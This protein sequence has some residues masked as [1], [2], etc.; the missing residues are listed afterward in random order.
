MA[1]RPVTADGP[2]ET[3]VAWPTETSPSTNLLPER[4]PLRPFAAKGSV[5]TWHRHPS[6][7][8]VR[9]RY[10]DTTVPMSTDP[11]PRDILKLS[12]A[13]VSVVWYAIIWSLGII[14]CVAA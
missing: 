11:Q 10:L 1:V 2:P 4:H 12:L 8:G 6:L 9:P 13:S 5:P 3:R 14:G 7:E